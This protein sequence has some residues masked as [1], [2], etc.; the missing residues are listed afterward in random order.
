MKKFLIALFL[1][2]APA[3]H[4][5]YVVKDGNGA[6]KIIK[7]GTVGGNILPYLS[8]VDASANPFGVIGNPFYVIC[9]SGCSGSGGGGNVNITQILGAAPS[10]TNPL[11]VAPASGATF[12]ISGSITC[13]NCSGS[14]VAVAYGGAI[15]TVG[16]PGGYKDGSGNFQP[17]LGDVT[18]GQW[19]AIKSS[20]ALTVQQPTGTNLHVV[21]DSGCSGGGGGGLSVPFGGAIGANGTPVGF[22]DG[23]GNL[24]P[25]LGDV[26]NG[27]WV[28]IKAS[29]SLPV[30]G[31]F[32][33]TTQPISATSLPLPTGAATQ[34]T[35]SSIDT[36]TPSLGQALA[37]ASV[38]VVLTAAQLTTLT[39]LSSVTV[40][41]ATGTNLHMVC[42]SGC[43]SSSSPTFGGT[44]P[45]TGTPVGFSQGGNFVAMTGTSGALN[46]NISSGSIAN[47]SF[48][49]TQ[50]TA[51]NLNATVVGTGTFAVQAAQSGTW[52]I[53]NISGTI[54]LPTGAGTSANQTA[55]QAPVAFATATATKSVLIGT[56]F[57]TTQP[58]ATN[59]QQGSLLVSSRG[60]LLVS[61]GVSG[62]PVTLTSTTITGTVAATQSGT[63]NV[64]N[65]SGTVSLPT[66]ASTSANQTSIIGSA[67]GG[68]AATSSQL[69]GGVF[70]SAAPTLTT[71][72]QASLQMDASGFLKVNVAAGGASGGTS[73][74]FGATFPGTGTAAGMSQAG[75]M[76]ALTGTSGNLN[77]Q[78]ANC[79]GSGVS[80]VDEAT[81][82]A[83]T[84]V[85]APG[86]GFFQTTATSNPLTT[87]QQGAFQVTANRALFTN[88][89]NA[90]GT[91]VGTSTTPL[92]V[93]LANTATNAT[94]VKVDGSGVTQP[95]SGTV[96]A[97]QGGTWTNT[98]TQATAA[99]LNATVVGTGTFSVQAAQS[100]TWNITNISGT[101]SLPTGAATS[102]NQPTNAA[103][104]ST[105]SGQTGYLMLGAT[106]TSAP[107]YTTAQSNPLSLTTAGAL[108]ID[109]SG[110]TQPVSGTIAFSNSTIAVTNTGTFA[111]QATLQASATTAIGK[112][113]PNTLGSWGLA[114][115]TQNVATPTNGML[116][117]AQFNTTPSTITSGNS[118]PLQLDN[119]GNLLVNIKAGASSGAVAQGSTTSGQTG[120]LTQAA[121]TTSAPT[122]TTAT[123]N[124]LSMDTSG[125]LRI[126][127]IT[128]C[129]GTGSI[130]NASSGV[131]TS[132]TNTGTVAYNYGFNGTTWDQL[133]VDASKFLKVNISAGTAAVTQAAGSVVSGAYLSGAFAS[134][135]MVDVTN[136]S[137]PITPTTATATKSALLGM[138]FNSTQA[139]FTNGQQG[140]VQG[141]SRGA[142]FVAT[143]A[144]TFNV[145]V[146]TALPAGTNLVG[147]VGI[148]QTTPGTTNGV[149]DAATGSTG[150]AVPSKASYTA[151]NSSGNLTGI[152]QADNSS[153]INVS[154]ATTTQ[155]VALSSTK[156]IYVTSYDVVAAGTGNI[157]FV[158]GTGTNCATGTTSLTGA[159]NLTAQ[160]GIAKGS[161]I[162]PVLVI[163]ASNALCVT[164]SAGVQMSGSVA[165]T[166]F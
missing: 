106:T 36:K 40:T 89:R 38:P 165:Y 135:S 81:F 77:V 11:W 91:E 133:Q 3:A 14:G 98:V 54:S 60:E 41:Q 157:T 109:G 17:N 78:C 146:N 92:Q 28:N 139:T 19:V 29:I 107:T 87:G 143:G 64:T 153:P 51:A 129:G 69:A 112:V 7:A 50:A 158:Y 162:G 26:T 121:V 104:G 150:S 117:Q 49:A 120:G 55:I 23:S 119:A 63:W 138:Q 140:S 34:T 114:A 130:S 94:A 152:I 123:T 25:L 20:I 118:S 13:A 59:T 8:P 111:V 132:S 66:G 93:S 56:Q 82:T 148:D 84:S 155:I 166:Q 128:G 75:N 46:V 110:T 79:S 43:S 101:I 32:F 48:A 102:A 154:T 159:Y 42:D 4:A 62:F 95:I 33:Q 125:N 90:A 9:Q 21:C 27:Q 2:I 142:L 105:T 161:G 39:P 156:K 99:S 131:A 100:G 65:I 44:F 145:T 141:S 67:S 70:N 52:N 35:L 127:C 10:A 97:N 122:Y 18:N 124:P 116:V 6:L 73:S 164:T 72:Q 136:L 74:T 15:G 71:G 57:L 45:T 113:D 12:P 58:T 80:A 160:S 30:T 163:P 47:T 24:Q 68:T 31:T 53:T 134:G 126:N 5:D 85:F 88:L 76:V 137:A 103:Q 144:D 16:T 108:R 22:K 151:A 37:A 149:Q 115:S 86:G 1:F 83:G 61:P 147:K 96:T